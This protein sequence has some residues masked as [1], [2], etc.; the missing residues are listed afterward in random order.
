MRRVIVPILV[1]GAVL[2]AVLAL[3]VTLDEES[4][5]VPALP[6]QGRTDPLVSEAGALSDPLASF[7]FAL[8]AREAAAT[9]ENVVVSPASIHAV[10]SMLLAGAEG[11]TAAELERGLALDGLTGDALGQA[12]AD[13]ITGSQAGEGSK[14]S[15]AD[16]LWLRDGVP[17]VQ[18]F[19]DY[20]RDYFAADMRGLPEDPAEAASQ[21]NEWVE[22]RTAGRIT[23]LV[24]PGDFSDATILTLVNT[25]YLKVKWEH[26][27][28][29]ATE[30]EPFTLASGEAV[31]V[32]MMHAQP[33]AGY[34]ATDLYD[35]VALDTDGPVTV[36][37]VVPRGE[38]TPEAVA[39]ALG[40][41]GYRKLLESARPL[42]G[43]LAVPRLSLEYES[44]RLKE[45]LEA[46]GISRA[47]SPAEAEF[48][49]VADLAETIYVEDILHKAD[50]DLDEEGVEAAAA[51]GAVVGVTSAPAE[52][53]AVRADRPFLVV[54]AEEASGAPLFT[55]LVRDPR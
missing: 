5:A 41:G 9:G 52:T 21:I 11:E 15:I 50:L 40:D 35:A 25:V 12:W 39:E 23:D 34:A 37:I 10:L 53:F 48:T 24:S 13:L 38:H 47:F 19:L 30:P 54:L 36:W 45:H 6:E 16:S 51:T 44:E 46:L 33:E 22:E 3:V 7:G 28:P 8:L 31:D 2:T 26:F 20:D 14:V 55:A 17:F 49:G 42:E 43:V 27:D 4:P 1:A 32:P 18:S 29:A